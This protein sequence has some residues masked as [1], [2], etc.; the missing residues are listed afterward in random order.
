MGAVA[1]ALKE[2]V[3]A[4]SYLARLVKQLLLDPTVRSKTTL[5]TF[6]SGFMSIAVDEMIH[7]SQCRTCEEVLENVYGKDL[8]ALQGKVALITGASNGLGLENARCLMKYGCHVIWAVRSPDKAAS[9]L[10][11]LEKKEKLTGKATILKIELSDLSSVKPFVESF[12]ALNLPLHYLICNA[13]IMS[14]T[15][16]L[17]SKQGFELQFATNNLSHFLLTEL[18]MPKLKETAKTG[19]VRV[20]ILSSLAGLT[21]LLYNGMTMAMFRKPVTKG[22]ATTM[23]CTVSPDV[24]EHSQKGATLRRSPSQG[25]GTARRKSLETCTAWRQLG[26]KAAPLLQAAPFLNKPLDM[27]KGWFQPA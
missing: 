19:E 1:S 3:I 23:Y 13:G 22:A 4:Y 18:L 2:E 21:S 5:L 10:N 11:Q 26:D 8:F 24:T 25:L 27:A 14:P 12:L 6:F 9:V 7:Q 17:P 15:E 20:V 16:W